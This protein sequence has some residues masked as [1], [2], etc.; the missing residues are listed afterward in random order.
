MKSTQAAIETTNA[1]PA[2]EFEPKAKN[3]FRRLLRSRFIAHKEMKSTQ[4][5]IETTNA[6]PAKEF[7]PEAKSDFCRLLL[8]WF[9][10]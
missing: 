1:R 2:K 9:H 7:E 6:K 5:A 8:K 4:G 3:D 10:C